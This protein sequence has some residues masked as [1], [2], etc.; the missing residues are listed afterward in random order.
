M[1]VTIK[2]IAEACGVSRG[3]V[4][5]VLNHRGRVSQEN[6][7]KINKAVEELGYKPNMLGKALASRKKQMKIGVI[8]C[9]VGNSFY[10]ELIRGITDA[11]KENDNYS[12]DVTFRHMKGY[13]V[14]KQLQLMDELEESVNC[15]VLTAIDDMQIAD[16][17]HEY[18]ERGIGVFTLNTDISGSDR[19]AH[20]GVDVV[21]CGRI[22]CG[23]IGLM[24]SEKARV[25]IATG[26]LSLLEH[27]ERIMGFRRNMDERYPY[28]ELA[29]I[30]ETQ[31][32]DDEAYRKTLD[33]FRR[34]QDIQAVFIGAGGTTGICRA[35]DELGLN[36]I[37]VVACD[38]VPE[39]TRQ[40]KRKRIEA[41]I[42]QQPWRQG[43]QA[44]TMAIRY[45][46][47]GSCMVTEVIH[48]EIKLYENLIPDEE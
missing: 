8:L 30:I 47:D 12:I 28:M 19:I 45:L 42:D 23:L 25:M 11:M 17:I 20:I 3:T 16:K 32:D 9:S 26:S 1:S 48:N 27:R 7:D 43:Y 22:A 38:M 10:E 13:H 6:I 31:D 44:L 4:D 35:L 24:C 5:R 46:V 18:M 36:E 41:A 34:S 29:E 33:F 14:K 37:R 40:M 2:M 39:V 21:E 15:L